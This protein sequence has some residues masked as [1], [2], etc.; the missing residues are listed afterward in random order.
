[1]HRLPTEAEWEYTCRAGTKTAYYFGDD[2]KELKQHGWFFTNSR[3][4]YQK[5]GQKALTLG[6]FTTHGNV[7]EWCLDQYVDGSTYKGARK[8]P[9]TSPTELYLAS[10]W[11]LG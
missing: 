8:N 2:P 11:R 7:W 6:G 3:F 4:Q 9:I 10:W 5:P 1:M